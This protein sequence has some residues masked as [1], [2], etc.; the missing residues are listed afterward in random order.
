[1][2]H[3]WIGVGSSVAMR[4]RVRV[5][6]RKTWL[7]G[8]PAASVRSS[9]LSRSVV[10][11]SPSPRSTP[12]AAGLLSSVASRFAR[13]CT[14]SSSATPWRASSSARPRSSSAKALAPSRWRL[15]RPRRCRAVPRWLSAISPAATAIT[16][17]AATPAS[18]ARSR[19]CAR[20]LA[21]RPSRRN[22][23]SVPLSSA[24]WLDRP[25]QR[26]GQAR[27]AVQ[28]GA[29]RVRSRPT[30][31]AASRSALQPAAL[32][33]LLEPAAQAR[34]LAQQRLV[35]DLGLAVA[36]RHQAL[37][38]ERRR[39]APTARR[40]RPRARPAA[41]AGA[42]RRPLALAREP[43]Q[44]APC[45]RATLGSRRSYALSAIRAIAPCTPPV[46]S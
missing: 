45:D 4:R 19:R 35:R 27:A 25:V 33:V 30:A 29:D 8:L 34:P 14:V 10:I 18:T 31:R 44:D 46:C 17:S 20:T 40:G 5:S 13:V 9:G 11:D 38:G 39:T 37:G 26:G 16:S 32:G 23:R 7:S 42:R 2:I 12:S 24:S 43:E 3:D 21:S 1:V 15:P 22:A 6:N 28:L 41:R 36:D